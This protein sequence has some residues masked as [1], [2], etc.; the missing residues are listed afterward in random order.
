MQRMTDRQRAACLRVME[1]LS[2][3]ASFVLYTYPVDV[4]RYPDYAD[5]IDQP[6]DFSTV[7]DNLR[8]NRYSS[9]SKWK[10]D[11]AL[12]WENSIMYNSRDSIYG[13]TAE[14]LR[15]TF[16][17]LSKHMED[18]ED[19]QWRMELNRLNRKVKDLMARIPPDIPRPKKDLSEIHQ[20]RP[21]F[22]LFNMAPIEYPEPPTTQRSVPRS[23]TGMGKG[24]GKTM[25]KLPPAKTRRPDEEFT[26]EEKNRIAEQVNSLEDTAGPVA[27]GKV[28]DLIREL[29]PD[30]VNGS[31]ELDI[32]IDMMSPQTLVA[33]RDLVHE[34]LQ[35]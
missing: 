28:F 31:D 16:W 27:V 32:D 34:F 35:E 22:E 21:A 20:S 15:D 3:H 18:D 23:G 24:K 12:I 29:E 1:E 25:G 4:S 8:H 13:W 19:T 7:C 6:M 2:A 33:L 17:R 26:Q 30:L 14:F 5:I 10:E 11:V 9:I